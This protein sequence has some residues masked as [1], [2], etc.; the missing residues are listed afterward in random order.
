M[1]EKSTNLSWW[2][3][4]TLLET[5]DT[6]EPLKRPFDRPLRLPIQNVYKISGIGT[7]PVGLIESGIM[8]P[9]HR[10]SQSKCIINNFQKLFQE[11]M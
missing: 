9:G 11:I 7:V 10:S 3:G 8:K 2:T 4:G 6:L 5:I 1:T